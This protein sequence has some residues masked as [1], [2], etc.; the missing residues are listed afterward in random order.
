MF[1][2]YI[3]EIPI[4]VIENNPKLNNPNILNDMLYKHYGKCIYKF[5][6]KNNR[7]HL[8]PG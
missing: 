6:E 8:S 4:E 7:L 3:Q 2:E 5:D 1:F